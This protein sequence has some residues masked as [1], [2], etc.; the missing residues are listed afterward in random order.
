M[1]RMNYWGV[2]A[3]VGGLAA[4]TDDK[5]ETDTDA[6]GTE[7]ASTSASGSTGATVPTTGD[8]TTGDGTT[9]DGTTGAPTTGDGTTGGVDV[10]CDPRVQDCP[11]GLKCTGYAKVKVDTWDANKCVPET[12]TEKV[13]GDPCSV[14]G[15]V[16]SGIDDC[17]KGYICLNVDNEGKN[18]ACV[19]FCTPDDM[20]P[21]TTGGSGI[22][23][24]INEGILPIC[25]PT[26]DPLVQDCP[27]QQGC[28]GDPMSGPPFICFAPDPQNGGMDGSACAFTNDCLAGLHCIDAAVQEGCIGS[29]YCCTPFCPIDGSTCTGAE[30][31]VAFF[32]EPFPGFENVGICVLPG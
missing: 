29:D 5:G 7:S 4:C 2:L 13:A 16:A 32:S 27:A 21:N 1:Q 12:N 14:E 22:C 24:P 3:L 20:C 6:S 9:G 17:S 26:C 18:G 30:E 19:E 28:Y 10:E 11:E 15:G 8:G 31:C 23:N 25:L